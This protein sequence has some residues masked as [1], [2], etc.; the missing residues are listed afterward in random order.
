MIVKYVPF[1]STAEPSFWMK[2][3]DYKLDTVKLS[4][5]AIPIVASYGIVPSIGGNSS[6]S[7][8]R[9]G[10]MRFDQDS[11][12]HLLNKEEDE[13][14]GNI[15]TMTM[16]D[17]ATVTPTPSPPFNNNNNN[18][19]IILHN[20]ERI[21]TSGK[22]VIL[23]TIESFKKANKNKML[24]DQCL[25]TILAV[26][27]VADVDG[28]T[29][30]T[31]DEE[32]EDEESL[33][34][35]T[36]FFCLTHLDLKSHKIVYWFA[37]PVLVPA[38]GRTIRYS[39]TSTT[40][41]DGDDEDKDANDT[42]NPSQLV[43]KVWG[44]EQ[45]RALAT[46]FHTMRVNRIVHHTK[47]SMNGGDG[48]GGGGCPPFFM[49]LQ[50]KE[51]SSISSD[52][53][54]MEC[55][56]LTARGYTNLSDDQRSNLTFA[57]IDPTTT[58]TTTA[59]TTDS[60]PPPPPPVGW[61]LR[62]LI[63][64]L[65]LKLNLAD[66]TVG[67]VSYRPGVIRRIDDAALTNNSPTNNSINEDVKN[68]KSLLL[69]IHLP[70]RTDYLWPSSS[71]TTTTTDTNTKYTLAGYELNTRS[72]PGP[73]TLNLS[74]LL[75][76]HHLVS[77]A[78][79]LNLKLM[80]WRQIPNLD[81]ST[82]STTRVLLLGAGTLGCAVARTLLGWG[83]RHITF[84]DG[85]K[86]SYSNPVRQSLF[87]V[88]DC[89]G[90]GR[91]K[92]VA[93]AEALGRIGGE[94]IVSEGVVMQIPMP[95]HGFAEGKEEAGV[96]DAVDKLRDLYDRHDVVYLLTDTR[97]SRWLPTV[98][99]RVTNTLTLNTALGLDGWLVM[100][101]GGGR[102]EGRL[103]CYFCND[104]VA[105]ENSTRDRTLDQQ[106]TVTRP[107][108]A[109][110]AGSMAVELMVALLHCREGGDAR[111]P[112][113]VVGGG[114]AEFKPSLT[115]VGGDGGDI[116]PL[117]IMPHQIRGSVVT[118]TMMTPTVPAFRYC[119]GCCDAVVEAY[120]KDEF[121]FLKSVCCCDDGSFLEDVAGLTKFR[122]DAEKMMEDCM[123]WEEDDSDVE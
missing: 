82:L 75:S 73:R 27:G 7:S 64:Y 80:K 49:I 113:P 68:D 20:N 59:N 91:D 92:A 14:A 18:S 2:L 28:T 17:A 102:E 15:S 10:R 43:T 70:K 109:G 48:D 90:G 78:T 67:I 85:G 96:K 9:T 13:L 107:G 88:T 52:S 69:K 118:Y 54:T 24:E 79:S 117:G 123:D 60:S 87:E 19:S 30:T 26:C 65:T 114:K 110:I 84:V 58:A 37:F 1:Q 38:P 72:K 21:G 71:T 108:L 33:E 47:K 103:G 39:E 61:T 86:V 3:G 89:V 45:T 112:K 25:S 56:E 98:L 31:I 119:T 35:L 122:E 94:G 95:G 83:V 97:E 105:P 106:C 22:I 100:R 62:N 40:T 99:G 104:V 51:S 12:N 121:E 66:Q 115:E 120:R 77:Q 55:L 57:F 76:P 74:P 44:L 81:L 50:N 101:H 63:A 32:E 11:M 23:N 36:T 8:G 5:D 29:P 41:N 42:T 93:A 111:A 116:S 4:E 34:G 53:N 46:A 16:D 6:G